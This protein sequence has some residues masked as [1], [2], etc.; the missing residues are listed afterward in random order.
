MEKNHDKNEV[1]TPEI[2]PETDPDKEQ[3]PETGAGTDRLADFTTLRRAD[4]SLE[5]LGVAGLYLL[6]KQSGFR[7]GVD[8]VLLT[9]FTGLKDRESVMDLCTGSG[10]IPILLAG[11]TRSRRIMGLELQAKYAEMA[12][13]SV[14]G[15][16]LA[17]RV[18]ILP[19]DVRDLAGLRTLD[20]FDVVTCNPPYK[21]RGHG[22]L[23]PADELMIARHEVAL[24]LADVI[25]AAAALLR[26]NG[27]LCLVHRPERL[28]DIYRLMAEH[29]LEL[30]RIRLVAPREGKAPNLLLV[31]G[32]RGQ[33]PYLKWEPELRVYRPDGTYTD[34]IKEI[35]GDGRH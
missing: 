11:K 4:E 32:V 22:L 31:E 33:R 5:D 20:K 10:I 14:S 15:N 29:G 21:A 17:E 18:T 3:Q 2:E 26:D 28:F 35:Y 12:A 25:R 1:K 27:R 23:N 6:Q 13:R 19:G 34:E 9:H 8:A 30:K 24:E 7:F 16:Q